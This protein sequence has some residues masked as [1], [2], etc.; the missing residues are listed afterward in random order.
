MSISELFGL[1]SRESPSGASRA[2]LALPGEAEATHA[3]PR[4]D[5]RLGMGV[6]VSVK[7]EVGMGVVK[8]QG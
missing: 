5:R 3:W 7:L 4:L 6:G 2:G 1:A 8:A